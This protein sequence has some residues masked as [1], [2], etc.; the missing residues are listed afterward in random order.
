MTVTTASAAANPAVPPGSADMADTVDT[1]DTAELEAFPFPA[2]PGS[3]PSPH[4]AERRDRCPFGEVRTPAGDRAILLV[5]GA[6]V[7]AAA[8]DT[9]LAHN[10]TAPGSPRLYPGSSFRLDPRL[11]TNMDGEEHL[12]LRRIVAGAFTPRSV[13]AW[14]PKLTAAAEQLCDALLAAGPP[15][16][17]MSAF[18]VQLPA[19]VICELLGLPLTDQPRFQHWA[20]AFLSVSPMTS[21]EREAAVEQFTEYVADLIAQRRKAPG[22]DLIDALIEARDGK[23]RLSESELLMMVLGLIAVGNEATGNSLGR[24]VLTLLDEDRRLWRELLADPALIPAAVDELLRY[25]PPGSMVAMRLATEDVELPSGT[26]RK[27]QGVLI[28]CASALRDPEI[29]PDPES[30]RFDRTDAPQ[31]VFSGGPHYCLGAHL[32]KAELRTA[33]A[34][35][36]ARIPD[37][38]LNAAGSDIRFSNGDILSTLLELP[39]AW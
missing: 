2:G 28:A 34:V 15:A 25:S 4:Y 22:H 30:V 6:D 29:Y 21:A 10:L 32:A 17:L 26:V 23:D 5:R 36:S 31:L 19:R 35:L 27:G 7:I 3:T 20:E 11:M 39:V 13:L 16:D 38:R 12:R 14:Q 1:L 24:A 8:A 37:L 9:R 33:L 18:C